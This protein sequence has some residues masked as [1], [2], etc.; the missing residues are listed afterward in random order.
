MGVAAGERYL[1]GSERNKWTDDEHCQ[2]ASI[3]PVGWDLVCVQTGPRPQI[4]PVEAQKG[5]SVRRIASV[6][7]VARIGDELGDEHSHFGAE[8]GRDGN[9]AGL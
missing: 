1:A 8:L 6:K 2:L 5:G 3:G 9:W 7:W 4:W